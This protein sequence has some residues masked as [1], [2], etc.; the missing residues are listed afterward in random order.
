MQKKLL[1]VLT[2][3]LLCALVLASCNDSLFTVTFDV[4]GQVYTTSN[5]KKGGKIAM[6]TPPQKSGYSFDGWYLDKDEWTQPFNS[7]VAVINNITVYAHWI[8]VVESIPNTY[9]IT[10]DSQGGS[11]V[12]GLR[13]KQGATFTLPANPTLKDYNFGGWY[14]DPA[15]TAQ[16]TTDYEL[17]RN[18]TVY[19]KWIPVDSTTYFVRSGSTITELT[20]LGKQASTI[21]LPDKL[22]GVTITAIADEL[23]KDNKSVKSVTFPS[24]S[25]YESVGKYA[26]SG[27]TNLTEIKF[28]NGIN[29][30]GEGAFSGCTALKNIQLP[31]A[32]TEIS[33]NMFAG[34]TSLQYATLY[35]SITAIGDGAYK[36][37]VALTSVRV[38][39]NVSSIGKEAFSGCSS[40]RS[41]GIDNGTTTIGEKAF[42]NCAKLTELVMPDSVTMVGSNALYGCVSLT[43]VTLSKNITEIPDYFL[44]NA[45]VLETL[46][47]PADNKI[48][49]IGASAFAYCTELENFA[50]PVGTTEIGQNAFNGCKD[51]TS[52]TCPVGVTKIGSQLFLNAV[53]LVSVSLHPNVTEIGSFAFS[54]CTELTTISGLENVTK[55]GSGVFKNAVKLNNIVIPAGVEVVPDGCFDTCRA[56]TNITLSDGIKVIDRLAF[57]G[58]ENLETITLPLTLTTIGEYAFDGCIKL[59]NVTIPSS[60]VSLAPTAFDNCVELTEIAVNNG[61]VSYEAD[62]GVI[63]TKGKETMVFYSDALENNSYTIPD[64]VKNLSTN[65]F[66]DNLKITTI[67]LPSTL[68][69]IGPSAFDGC[70]NLANINFNQGLKEIGSYAFE[71][72]AITTANLPIGLVTIDQYAFKG[73]TSLTDAIIP[74]TALSVGKGIFDGCRATLNVTVEGDEDM[75]SGWSSSWNLA[76]NVSGYNITYGANRITSGDYQYFARGDYAV[77]TDYR[78]SDTIVSVPSTIDGKTVVGLYKTFNRDSAITAITVPNSV[79]TISEY[80]FKGMSALTTMT[81]PFV[82]GY[83]GADGVEGLFGYAFDYSEN[84]QDEWTIQSAEGGARDSYYTDIPKSVTSVTITDTTTIAYGAFS[85]CHNIT[86][87]VLP[88]NIVEIKGKA[89]YQ[90]SLV[91]VYLPLCLV[92]VGK[93][94]FTWNFNRSQ[95]TSED[96][97]SPQVTFNCATQE[98][99]AGWVEGG[100]DENSKFNYSV[101]L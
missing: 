78:G 47:I 37:C 84:S 86:N 48:T 83:R 74:I 80:T 12:P 22:G 87:I 92:S 16:F 75:L 18:I 69:S 61:S 2:I 98:R 81:I 66:R 7:S 36:D 58:C 100:F 64:G 15:C 52:F 91:E 54:G 63:F 51:I 53:N 50:I 73:T 34:C 14:L 23:F 43:N 96:A 41:I 39:E 8:R 19:A 71:N 49:K 99:P 31:T 4:D 38:R 95:D 59:N 57:N 60:V 26:F 90:C 10:F 93:E 89:F 97:L 46:T 32:I 17:T 67:V 11:T 65:L 21:T 27:C 24:G 62:N 88:A 82:G 44:Y 94:A 45:K 70:K 77:L 25:S 55:L 1:V 3:I 101:E 56:L 85:K 30:I 28:I 5:V 35:D 33:K 40:I 76:T 13:V 68:E 9:T 20:A 79:E 72:T 6:P 42:Y 29:S